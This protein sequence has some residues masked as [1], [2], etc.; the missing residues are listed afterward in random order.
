MNKKL[1]SLVAT[2]SL[3]VVG[4]ALVFGSPSIAQTSGAEAV[5]KRIK[6]MRTM[7]KSFG[8][9]V[10]IAK[11]ESTDLAVAGAAAQTMHDSMVEAATLFLEGTAKADIAGSRSKPEVWS[12]ADEFK[13]A[14]DALIKASADIVAA[15]QSGDIDS[16][17]SLIRPLGAACG[18]C[19]EGKGK[20]GG[21]FR[22][23]KEG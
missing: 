15:A 7:G 13:T 19:H 14:S 9:I 2:A 16:F 4:A 8:P 3:A 6:L 21:K 20:A 12:K 11:G 18:G 17:K 5:D 1:G 10:A 23:P 22:F